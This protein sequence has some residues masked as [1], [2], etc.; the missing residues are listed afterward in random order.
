VEDGVDLSGDV[1]LQAADD[2]RLGQALGGAPLDVG[3]GGRM[4]A[5]A[6]DHDAVQGGVGLAVTAAVQAVADGRAGGGFGRRRSAEHGEGGLGAEALW[7][8]ACR[9]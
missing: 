4:V 8:V 7:V 1:A 3:S 5:H 9:D 6:D 2:L